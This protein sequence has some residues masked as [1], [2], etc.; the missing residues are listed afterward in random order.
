MGAIAHQLRNF[1]SLPTRVDQFQPSGDDDTAVLQ[2]LNR[3]DA[4]SRRA[5]ADPHIRQAAELAA[6]HLP[7]TAGSR[8]KAAAVW[9]WVKANVRF[10]QDEDL[11]PG[12]REVLIEP[13]RL[14]TMPEPQGDC[15]DF[16]MLTCSMLAA[17]GV[18][19]RP[20][21]VAADPQDPSRFSH[22]Y[23]EAILED[24]ARMP[25]DASHGQYAGWEVPANRVHRRLPWRPVTG[26]G[27][28]PAS[29]AAPVLLLTAALV[30]WSLSHRGRK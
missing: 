2:T 8:E 14:V 27:D 10:V 15:D 9:Q 6:A 21:A 16:T 20:V 7:E 12:V 29:A 19:A 23:A 3:M 18:P 13:P 28:A 22:V 5:A 26:L 24:G 11:V 1:G 25:L 17:L 30:S 4:I